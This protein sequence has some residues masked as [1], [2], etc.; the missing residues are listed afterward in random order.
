MLEWHR[1]LIRLR[2]RYPE[3]TD[4]NLGEVHVE[5]DE[6]ARCLSFRRGRVT[7]A[8]NIGQA[9]VRIVLASGRLGLASGEGVHLVDGELVLPPDSVAVVVGD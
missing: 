1:A 3:L 5:F 8:F 4:G 2:G 9:E 6:H 7:V